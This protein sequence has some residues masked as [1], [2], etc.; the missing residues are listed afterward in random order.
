MLTNV[1][2]MERCRGVLVFARATLRL[3][4]H[5]PSITTE[6]QY[7]RPL[8]GA[9]ITRASK[10]AGSG[11]AAMAGRR[12]PNRFSEREVTRAMR[13]VERAGK[14]VDRVEIDPGNGKLVVILDKSGKAVTDNEVE[15][16]VSR[17]GRYA[18]H[19]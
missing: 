18:D 3:A 7:A 12:G 16:W 19:R 10:G 6:S 2:E 13:A 5:L 8:K 15:N 14:I 1:A 4:T 17:Q 11:D 9:E